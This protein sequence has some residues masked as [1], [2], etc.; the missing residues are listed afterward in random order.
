MATA[1]AKDRELSDPPA[2]SVV[3]ERFPP[4]SANG[5]TLASETDSAAT[6][7]SAL[8]QVIEIGVRRMD[9]D[10]QRQGG[11]SS[12]PN[13]NDERLL[14][15]RQV[16]DKLGVSERFIWDH[17]TRRSPRIPAVKL[18]KLIRYRRADVDNF[19]AEL[20]TLPPSRRSRFGV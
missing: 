11:H 19:M 14:N 12:Q 4:V 10:S 5:R 2:T 17:T 9:A 6:Q 16:A 1:I 15:A 13:Q 8:R 20:G 7:D 3:S 18:G